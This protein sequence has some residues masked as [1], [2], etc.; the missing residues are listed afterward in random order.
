MI[1][2]IQAV[3]TKAI[4]DDMIE[5]GQQVEKPRATTLIIF[6]AILFTYEVASAAQ[7]VALP[8]LSTSTS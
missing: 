4:V 3:A 7:V 8:S 1:N 6:D 5:A 2:P